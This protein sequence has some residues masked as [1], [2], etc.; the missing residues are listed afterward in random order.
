MK[1]W[2]HLSWKQ[3]HELQIE[4]FHQLA[5]KQKDLFPD[6]LEF[7]DEDEIINIFYTQYKRERRL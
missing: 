2:T 6:M 3:I 5:L 4:E 1:K 7:C